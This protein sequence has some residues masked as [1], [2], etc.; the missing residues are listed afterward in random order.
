MIQI[1]PGD[2]FGMLIV[3]QC[4]GYKPA[5]VSRINYYRCEC[6][7][8]KVKDIRRNHLLMGKTVSCGCFQRTR[9]IKPPGQHSFTTLYNVCKHGARQRNIKF[10]L[11]KEEHRFIVTRP[12]FYCGQQPELHNSYKRKDGTARIKSLCGSDR[13]DIYA[14]GVDR[15]DNAKGYTL[16]NCVSCC[17]NC[18]RCKWQLSVD[19]FIT[20]VR[21]IVSYQDSKV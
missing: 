11:S 14:N 5:L 2:R 15:V 1:N 21:K 17:S 4:V 19:Q 18:N 12:C 6:D 7:C 9:A 16:D 3:L 10:E 20:H 13:A 8:G